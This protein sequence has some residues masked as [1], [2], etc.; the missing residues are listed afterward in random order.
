MTIASAIARVVVADVV[1]LDRASIHRSRIGSSRDGRRRRS[2]TAAASSKSSD[3]AAR[4]EVTATTRRRRTSGDETRKNSVFVVACVACVFVASRVVVVAG[5]DSS[6]A[7]SCVESGDTAFFVAFS[8]NA[9]DAVFP[10]DYGCLPGGGRGVGCCKGS[11]CRTC[12]ERTTDG[13]KSY[14]CACEP[15]PAGSAQPLD[16]E[17]ECAECPAGWYQNLA[18][19]A[20]CKPC[21]VGTFSTRVGNAQ[22]SCTACP[23]GT[24]GASTR[25]AWLEATTRSFRP[26]PEPEPG[27]EYDST[28]AATSCEDCAPGTSG[29]GAGAACE[30]CPPGTY[31][32]GAAS[33]CTK[34]PVGTYN[35]QSGSVSVAACK[36]CPAGETNDA[37]GSTSCYQVC[38]IPII[39]CAE[40]YKKTGDERGYYDLDETRRPRITYV[41]DEI[42]AYRAKLCEDGCARFNTD[43]WC[44][45]HGN[46]TEDDCDQYRSPPPPP[47]T[48]PP[49]PP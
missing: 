44:A 45:S 1:A 42:D 13:L 24:S 29:A 9:P 4:R 30:T 23:A 22:S 14:S 32:Y 49:A 18:G 37:E 47:P 5:Q 2:Q 16:G 38:P 17:S 48:P 35:A 11:V 19:Q 15:C 3:R 28:L 40:A 33:E 26:P 27:W 6:S 34:C 8:P 7:T 39:A 36:T 12:E 43:H 21:G 20:H 46:P 31:S 10:S 41:D 25:A